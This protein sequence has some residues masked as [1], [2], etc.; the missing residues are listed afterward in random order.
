MLTLIHTHTRKAITPASANTQAHKHMKQLSQAKI[1]THMLITCSYPPVPP[2][3][4]HTHSHIFT[5]MTPHFPQQ[6]TDCV[7]CLRLG[8]LLIPCRAFGCS[9]VMHNHF[10]TLTAKV[11]VCECMCVAALMYTC[12]DQAG[13]GSSACQCSVPAYM[14]LNCHPG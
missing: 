11:C 5:N 6:P 4:T 14:I 8:L 9:V 7:C 3:S 2:T 10:H 1:H 12:Q 13:G